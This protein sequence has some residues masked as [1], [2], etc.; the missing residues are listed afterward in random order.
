MKFNKLPLA[1]VR[2]GDP[3][4]MREAILRFEKTRFDIRRPA[5]SKVQLKI[6]PT[7]SLYPTTGVIYRDGDPVPL[8]ET[9][10]DGALKLLEDE[11]ESGSVINLRALMIAK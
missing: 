7:L 6:S 3:L 5:K 9:G 10:V 4:A 1:A 11:E 2:P 8:A